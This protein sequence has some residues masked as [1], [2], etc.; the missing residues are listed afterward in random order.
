MIVVGLTGLKRSGKD[1]VADRLVEEH[2]F[3]K[4]AYADPLRD[5]ALALDPIVGVAE[6]DRRWWRPR[7]HREAAGN[8]RLSEAVTD[9]GWE[10]AK[11]YPE[12]RR[13]LQRLGTEVIRNHI[14][15][16][17]WLNRMHGRLIRLGASR[18]VITDCR[19]PN[20]VDLVHGWGGTVLLVDR[21]GLPYNDP[22][23]SEDVTS[24]LCDQYIDNDGTLD[25]LHRKVDNFAATL[26]TER[27]TA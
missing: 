27:T 8:Y 25:D 11:E 1:T 16:D 22:H 19:F 17:Y 15:T 23:D 20:E 18:V 24:L 2:G 14:G 13:T 3:V 9:L 5:M 12:V 6:L 21:P 4:V 26:T 10:E 7:R